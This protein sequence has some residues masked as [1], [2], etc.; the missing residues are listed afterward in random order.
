MLAHSSPSKMARLF[1]AIVL[2]LLRSQT[3]GAQCVSACGQC[4]LRVLG[5]GRGAL[6]ASSKSLQWR[7]PHEPCPD[8]VLDALDV[9][10]LRMVHSSSMRLTCTR[11]PSFGS[12]AAWCGTGR[13]AR[14]ALAAAAP[15][16]T[17]MPFL[18]T[19]STS[20]VM[21]SWP[22]RS[23]AASCGGVRQGRACAC[24]PLDAPAPRPRACAPAPPAFPSYPKATAELLDEL[25][26]QHAE[27][28]VPSAA[29]GALQKRATCRAPCAQQHST[30]QQHHGTAGSSC[31]GLGL[32]RLHS[33]GGTAKLACVH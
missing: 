11:A 8:A 14:A 21:I 10:L 3:A 17:V 29:T 6:S 1:A 13:R 20:C 22:L 18:I 4:A 7:A 31:K 16:L 24:A 28:R 27:R 5:A 32:P 26:G 19:A 33:E 9:L 12:T 23:A 15:T 2:V 30:L 25:G